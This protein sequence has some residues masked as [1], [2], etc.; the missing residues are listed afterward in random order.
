MAAVLFLGG[1][2]ARRRGWRPTLSL[3]A[4]VI[5]VVAV[6]ATVAEWSS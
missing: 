6:L 3:T 1:N 2:R 5:G 4:A